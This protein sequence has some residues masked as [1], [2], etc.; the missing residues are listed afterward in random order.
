MV[1]QLCHLGK[2]AEHPQVDQRIVPFKAGLHSAVFGGAFAFVHLDGDAEPLLFVGNGLEFAA[3]NQSDA[4]GRHRGIP[5]ALEAVAVP[6]ASA[7]DLAP[8]LD[9]VVE[10]DTGPGT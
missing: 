1:E 6:V 7:E 8:V 10:A 5:A 9:Q 4:T 3:R 2:L